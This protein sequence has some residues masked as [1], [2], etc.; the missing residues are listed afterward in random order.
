MLFRYMNLFEDGRIIT[1]TATRLATP[2]LSILLA[3]YLI[4]FEFQVVGQ[5]LFGGKVLLSLA[6]EE[7]LETGNSLDLLINF[8]DFYGSIIVLV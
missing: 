7:A 6:P 2:F 3:F 4:T 5:Q 1:L 8:N